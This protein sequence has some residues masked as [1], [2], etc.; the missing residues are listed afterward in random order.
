MSFTSTRLGKIKPS[1][2]VALTGLTAEL[3]EAG[4]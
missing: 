4:R 2:T 1:A 3:K